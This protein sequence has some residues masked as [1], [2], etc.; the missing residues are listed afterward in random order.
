MRNH[1]VAMVA[2]TA[3]TQLLVTPM[4]LR[5]AVL[6]CVVV[7]PC[8]RCWRVVRGYHARMAEYVTLL[9]TRGGDMLSLCS[10]RFVDAGMPE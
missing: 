8:F 4:K 9:C 6:T 2:V 3:D 5:V 7:F 1:V 10:C